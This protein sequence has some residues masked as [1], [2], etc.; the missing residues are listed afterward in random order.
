MSWRAA[1]EGSNHDQW[2]HEDDVVHQAEGMLSVQLGVPIG[3]AA[4]TLRA[5]SRYV[6]IRRRAV[7]SQVTRRQVFIPRR[8][9]HWGYGSY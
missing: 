2:W 5:Y 4:A 9:R 1:D 7:A 6:G 8:D 3:E